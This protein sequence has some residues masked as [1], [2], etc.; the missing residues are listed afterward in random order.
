[1]LYGELVWRGKKE[2]ETK[3]DSVAISKGT[4]EVFMINSNINLYDVLTKEERKELYK[5]AKERAYKE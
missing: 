3:W 4:L 5:E 2:Y 1:M